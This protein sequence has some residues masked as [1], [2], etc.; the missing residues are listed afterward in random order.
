VD[1]YRAVALRPGI[2][3]G[4][5]RPPSWLPPDLALLDERC[6]LPLDAPFTAQQAAELGVSRWFLRLLVDRALV[7][8]VLR[9]TYVAAQVV[10]SVDL[11]AAALRLVVPES[12]VVTDRTAA[13]LH[14]VD[15]LP[16]SAVHEPPPLCVFGSTGS[17]LRRPEVVSGV[18]ALAEDDITLVLGV[19]VTTPLRTALDLGRSLWRF[20]A[21][22]ALDGFLRIGVRHEHIL[23][24]VERFRG[25]RGVVQLRWL[26]PL[27]DGRSES[28]GESALRLHWYDAGLPRPELQWWVHADGVALYRLDIALPEIRFAAEYDGQRFHAGADQ[29][30]HD[31]NRRSWLDE[32][33]RW[34]VEAFEQEHVYS[35]QA[36]PAPRLQEGAR[37]ASTRSGLWV[38]ESAYRPQR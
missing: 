13:W 30:E 5:K 32:E 12:A 9:G 36:D 21:L 26:A 35:Q 38:P 20:D 17:R 16:R 15:I 7:R 1:E 27:A 29:R 18:R 25:Q 34:V 3:S 22:A 4:M 6:P 24:S 23:L 28:P 19:R 33:R 11:R 14:G 37:L 31:R 2:L 10:D 8:R